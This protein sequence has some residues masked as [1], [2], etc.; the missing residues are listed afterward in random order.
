[1]RQIIDA[2]EAARGELVEWDRV[3]GGDP[4]LTTRGALAKI[5]AAL[6]AAREQQPVAWM[7]RFLG[8]PD[9]SGKLPDV[10]VSRT[11]WENVGPWEEIPLYAAPP[12]PPVSEQQPGRYAVNADTDATW[13]QVC[14]TAVPHVNGV[15]D[16]IAR[17]LPDMAA[18]IAALLNAA[19]PAPDALTPENRA[20][21][22]DL[23]SEGRISI[24]RAAE[25]F[26]VSIDTLMK[27]NAARGSEHVR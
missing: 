8:E 3:S 23:I 17:A 9:R 25:L 7:Y 12:A 16:P 18:R 27:W 11:R 22:C 24:G 26:G 4:V 13:H 5:N 1:M 15:G 2:L 19:P 14:D 21:V 6:A 20:I 10:V